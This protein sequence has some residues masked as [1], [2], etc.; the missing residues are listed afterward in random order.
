[1]NQAKTYFVST[2]LFAL[3]L[4]HQTLTSNQKLAT[5]NTV[6]T[7]NNNN[8]DFD[9][10]FDIEPD[11]IDD[12]RTQH[13]VE[14][15]PIEQKR[16]GEEECSAYMA[17]LGLLEEYPNLGA[18]LQEDLYCY[19]N[20]INTRSLLDMPLFTTRLFHP[21]HTWYVSADLFWNKT[22]NANFTKKS[23]RIS[24]YLA[25]NNEKLFQLVPSSCKDKA[26]VIFP[27]LANGHLEERRFGS[28]LQAG[29]IWNHFTLRGMAPLYYLERNYQL[30]QEEKNA[31][32]VQFGDVTE[33]EQ[34]RFQREHMI[35]DKFGLGDVRLYGE[36]KL[37]EKPTCRINAGP[38]VT[39]PTA[40]A[41]K[42]GLMGSHYTSPCSR[43]TIN[44]KKTCACLLHDDY[45]DL[46][47]LGYKALDNLSAIILEESLG[48]RRH[49]GIGGFF[50]WEQK[51]SSI[52][53]RPWTNR[54][55]LKNYASC[56]YL[57]PGYERRSFIN[58]ADPA[59]Y[60]KRDFNNESQAEDNLLF[61]ETEL[62]DTIFPYNFKTRV[63]P[64]YVVWLDSQL[65]YQGNRM[66]FSTGLDFW[67]H[68]KE[69][70]SHI[71]TCTIPCNEL[72]IDRAHAPC[73]YQGKLLGSL[74][75]TLTS[76]THQWVMGL[77]AD[78][79]CISKGIGKDYTVNAFLRASF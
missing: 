49:F 74:S 64:G 44:L 29:Y 33:D 7:Q 16:D 21:P 42:K 65:A 60:N 22:D 67:F 78:K 34:E 57:L 32:M 24:S 31:L 79:T 3:V 70:L 2:L 59:D 53:K 19:T 38:L 62:I 73:A 36:F 52:I 8:D 69:K 6:T 35:S 30:T 13:L 41:F 18:I 17:I 47:N 71:K 39:L 45:D 50:D 54:I 28:M 4:T 37:F 25:L 56:E 43:P 27:A 12:A 61:I 23:T 66:G 11:A 58:P 1:M 77:G 51:L 20:P 9:D 46:I 40:F 15:T 48:N 26:L 5:S 10:L 14:Q 55:N 72:A 68:S 76:P 75:Y 63:S